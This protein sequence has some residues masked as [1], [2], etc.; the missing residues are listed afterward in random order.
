MEGNCSIENDDRSIMPSNRSLLF[1]TTPG[2][3]A[4]GRFLAIQGLGWIVYA[5]QKS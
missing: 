2:R 5:V 1:E 4:R 3:I